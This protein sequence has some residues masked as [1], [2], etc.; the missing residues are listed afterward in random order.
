MMRRRQLLVGMA[1]VPLACKPSQSAERRRNADALDAGI[2]QLPEVKGKYLLIGERL[3]ELRRRAKREDPAWQRLLSHVD[4]HLD[5]IGDDS[6]GAENLALVHLVTDKPVYAKAALAKAR[7]VM[8]RDVRTDSY[9]HI[10][11]IVRAV[12]MVLDYC[13]LKDGEARELAD[14]VARW[15]HELW[16]DNKGSGWALDDPGNNYHM[17]FLES[18]AYAGYALAKRRDARGAPLVVLLRDKIEGEGGVLSYLEGAAA[19]GDWAE[20]SNY[21]Q[22]AKQRLLS[23]FGA[24]A[25]MGGPRYFDRTRFFRDAIHY[26]IYQLQPDLQ[27]LYPAGD[28]SRD[29][30]MRVCP[31]DRD[32]IQMATYWVREPDAKALGRWYLAQAA[33]SY[34][35]G[36]NFSA[37]LHKDVIFA[38][39]GPVRSPDKLPKSYLARGTGW[40]NVRSGWDRDATSLCVSACA[41]IEQ[42]HAHL[43]AGAFTLFKGGW[44]AV[45]AATYSR[46]GITW[47]AGAHNLVHVVGH[48]RRQGKVGGLTRFHHGDGIA[49]MQVDATN[50]YR[51][52]E[53]D[54]KERMLC[55]EYTREIVFI[56]PDTVVVYDRV[57][58][59]E[60]VAYQQRTHFAEK[61]KGSSGL[62]Q[63]KQGRGG[64]SLLVLL[65]GA[66]S[67]RSDADLD[68]DGSRAWRV[69]IEPS[70]RPGRFLTVLRVGLGDAPP[71]EATAIEGDGIAGVALDDHVVVFSARPRGAPL[72]PGWRY[73]VSD[74]K[75]THLIFDAQGGYDVQVR[76]SGGEAEIELARGSTRSADAHGILRI[77]V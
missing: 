4:K 8:Q 7:A 56:E 37:A 65:G 61:P 12:A 16:F 31:Y 27:S 24:I 68:G 13:K 1:L 62:Y 22:R 70:S 6:E 38:S 20:G 11:D 25:S 57:S 30:S 74:R 2:D 43:D 71:L 19:G 5:Q 34:D 40:I 26:A 9:L 39:D 73:R 10:G 3:P 23:A 76:R 66:Q 41:A 75:R 21:G 58:V 77:Q 59:P 55:E 67:I 52:R 35:Q 48:E 15:T 42:S 32:Y 64:M 54:K 51:R 50:L 69:E 53:D 72:D 45:D 14:F 44:Q 49:Y 33:P 17:A 28:L 63:A 29:S 47:E 46:S 36:F 60:G 18:T